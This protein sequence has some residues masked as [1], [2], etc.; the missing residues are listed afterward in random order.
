MSSEADAIFAITEKLTQTYTVDFRRLLFQLS[1]DLDG[2]LRQE[3]LPATQS[4]VLPTGGLAVHDS[5]A[6]LLAVHSLTTWLSTTAFLALSSTCP[7]G[8]P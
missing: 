5:S 2:C 7:G 4:S 6:K 3:D 8:P 1:A